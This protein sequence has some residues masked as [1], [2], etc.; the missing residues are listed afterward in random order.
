MI[1]RTHLFNPARPD[2]RR[3]QNA[4]AS[5]RSLCNCFGVSQ[6][7]VPAPEAQSHSPH[8]ALHRSP[9]DEWVNAMT[10]GIGLVLAIIGALVMGATLW[11]EGDAW[12]MIGCSIF[13]A[14]MI[15]VYAASTISHTVSH[16][17]WKYVFRCVDQ[18]VIYLLVVGTYTPFGL[19]YLR[20]GP[21][22][23]LLVGLWIGA[24]IG[25]FA[26]VVFAHRVNDGSVWSYVVL[27]L[28]PTIVIPYLWHAV[29]A[30]T[31]IWM[32][33]GGACY[34][35]GT[36]F[37]IYEA[38]ARHFHAVWHLLVIAGSTCHFLGILAA[39]ARASG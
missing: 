9:A 1:F 12:R 38:R 37:L 39:V 5:F 4:L 36:F 16:P 24:V 33:L 23:V 11:K 31:T 26:K 35:V 30:G 25:F 13:L 18:G 21:G 15:A 8:S 32:A 10:H 27:G 14:S 22:W 19:A 34:L 6:S 17:R 3:Q 7:G 29:P 2:Q 28:L 20:T